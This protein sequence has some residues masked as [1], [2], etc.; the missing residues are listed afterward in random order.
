MKILWEP[1]TTI[2]CSTW[3]RKNED[4]LRNT[5]INTLLKHRIG[6][7]IFGTIQIHNKIS[8]FTKVWWSYDRFFFFFFLICVSVVQAANSIEPHT[9]DRPDLLVKHKALEKFIIVRD[10]ILNFTGFW[11][12]S[13]HLYALKILFHYLVLVWNINYLLEKETT[14][15]KKKFDQKL[16]RTNEKTHVFSW[17][18]II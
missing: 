1:Q 7:V 2:H 4:I 16:I 10:P 14:Q 9:C 18:N 3:D 13:I 15:I 6:M 11:A 12:C 5:H 8:F 17:C